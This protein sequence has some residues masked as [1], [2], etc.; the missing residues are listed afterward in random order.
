MRSSRARC[1]LGYAAAALIAGAGALQGA[2]R[3]AADAGSAA[4]VT[5]SASGAVTVDGKAQPPRL[6]IQRHGFYHNV[7]VHNLRWSDWG[8]ASATGRG[9]FTFQFCVHESCS[10]SPFF[11]EPVVVTL[12][13]V[14]PCGRR[15]SYTA[16][17]LDIEASMPDSSFT[18]F[19]TSLGSCRRRGSG[20][21]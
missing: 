4:S 20:G 10:V 16:L 9:T 13:G 3:V 14:R 7:S 17:A 6:A 11:D 21:H 2:A 5:G 19:Q 15:L 12:S 18:H 1:L 8:Q